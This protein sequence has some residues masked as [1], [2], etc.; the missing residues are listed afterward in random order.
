ML[1]SVPDLRRK[2]QAWKEVALY[3]LLSGKEHLLLLSGPAGAT[4]EDYLS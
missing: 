2:K 1:P 4:L 3:S